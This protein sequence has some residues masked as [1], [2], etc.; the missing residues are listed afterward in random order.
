MRLLDKAGEDFI[1]KWERLRLN[2]YDDG[3]GV[4]TIGYGHTATT[5][6]G[7]RITKE[8]AEELFQDDVERYVRCINNN[9]EVYLTQNQFNALV[10]WCFNVGVTA[11]RNSTL[12]KLL[13]KEEYDAIPAQLARWNKVGG[14]EVRGLT[15]RRAE[16][17]VLWN[18]SHTPVRTGDA[19]VRPSEPKGRNIGQLTA[20][21]K[22]VKAGILTGGVSISQ[23]T[24]QMA[25]VQTLTQ[26]LNNTDAVM[27]TIVALGGVWFIYNRWR[28]SRDGVAQ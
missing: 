8:Q 27:W 16:E 28:D 17:S 4:H 5:N 22:T 21:S 7:D 2:A 20:K 10:S 18:S 24:N 19:S 12:L 23:L 26:Y 13:N 11:A 3:Y 1:K 14:R 25:E 15:R 6:P 9:V